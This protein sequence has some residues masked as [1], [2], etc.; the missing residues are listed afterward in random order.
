MFGLSFAS[1]PKARSLPEFNPKAALH[2]GEE[3]RMEGQ[4][5]EQTLTD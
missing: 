2:P 3:N 5:K 1:F 4:L